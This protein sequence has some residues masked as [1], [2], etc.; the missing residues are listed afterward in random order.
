MET[1][2]LSSMYQLLKED[3]IDYPL[4]S[5]IIPTYNRKYMLSRL[6][7]S[8]L[9]S[10]YPIDKLEIIVVDDTSND[11]TY[12]YIKERHSNVIIYRNKEKKSASG[13]RNVGARCAKGEYL[14]FIDDDNIIDKNAILNLIKFIKESK[15]F[16]VSPLML[17]YSSPSIIWCAGGKI[18]K[19]TYR[20][21]YFYK[22]QNIKDI[23][24]PKTI[25]CDYNPNAF[26]MSRKVFETVGGFDEILFPISWDDVDLFKR[27]N[28]LGFPAKTIISSKIWH[29]IPLE[30]F[31]HIT[32]KRSYNRGK[33]RITFYSK[34]AKW[35]I[36]LSI[37]D[38]IYF[39][40]FILLLGDNVDKKSII[41]SYIKGMFD[42]LIRRL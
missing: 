18:P 12:E 20:P 3:D 17:Y 10:N 40:F 25:R 9:Q 5:I 6:I 19:I 8:I 31:F 34:Y 16:I 14:F 23:N 30:E 2:S 21:Y 26:M 13:S 22:K 1:F 37:V 39:T 42:G 24:P 35:R 32:T 15:N 38:I 4:I 33:T 28:I 7:D 27:A 41:I 29:D 36:V 11:N